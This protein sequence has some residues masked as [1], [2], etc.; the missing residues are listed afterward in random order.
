MQE[1]TYNSQ[2]PKELRLHL[3]ES[4]LQMLKVLD[5][6]AMDNQLRDTPPTQCLHTQV[7]F[8]TGWQDY[9]KHLAPFNVVCD[10]CGIVVKVEM[11]DA[12][13][14]RIQRTLGE[15]YKR[16]RDPFPRDPCLRARMLRPDPLVQKE[17]RKLNRRI[18]PKQKQQS[19]K[20]YN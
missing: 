12:E 3:V 9:V 16:K 14:C 5:F 11:I 10:K 8:F 2:W 1:E 19:L 15:D 6:V 18:R 13:E 17:H 20:I 4:N 7:K